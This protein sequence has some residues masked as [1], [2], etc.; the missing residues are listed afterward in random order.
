[1]TSRPIQHR[2]AASARNRLLEAAQHGDLDA[3]EQLARLYE[4]LVQ[5]VVWKLKLPLGCEREDLAQEARVGLLAAIRAWRPERG[6]FPAF[7]DRC[8]SNQ[9]LLALEA[10][11]AHKHQVL[12]RAISL[13][14]PQDWR[15]SPS[16]DRPSPALIETLAARRDTATDP[17][18]R[19]LVHEQLTSVRRA[20]PSLTASERAGL[21][22]ARER[23][24]PHAARVHAPRLAAR[25]V[26]GGPPRAPQA[27]RR[28]RPGSLT[29]TRLHTAARSEPGW[30]SLDEAG[31][32]GPDG[33]PPRPGRRRVRRVA[34]P[35]RGVEVDAR[36]LDV[37][38]PGVGVDRH[39]SPRARVADALERRRGRT[40]AA[41]A[42][43]ARSRRPTARSRSPSEQS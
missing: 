8:V 20:L 10:T 13:D 28:P 25:R 24:E 12:S 4:P 6:P 32:P 38:V 18:L 40:L 21:A 9:A 19:L 41:A 14:A 43:S 27:R 30:M 7:A 42:G 36:D 17:E 16:H 29:I 5:R 1:M 26:A 31:R 23:A 33:A 35:R 2:G 3:H 39:P 11:A 37:G 22:M 15:A 34:E